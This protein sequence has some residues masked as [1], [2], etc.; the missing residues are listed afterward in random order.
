AVP[1][2]S[3]VPSTPVHV[4]PV[5]PAAEGSLMAPAAGGLLTVLALGM[6]G[7]MAAVEVGAGAA[8]PVRVGG[9][10]LMACWPPGS[11]LHFLI[12]TTWPCAHD[13]HCGPKRAPGKTA[14]MRTPLIAFGREP[15]PLL[16][17]GLRALDG[18]RGW[19]TRHSRRLGP[20]P[21]ATI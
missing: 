2:L 5:L 19:G 20:A 14:G 15:D 1:M 12:T 7:L 17:L 9:P 10:T 21:D 8:A 13:M 6:S 3:P 16:F 11:I 4:A 18:V